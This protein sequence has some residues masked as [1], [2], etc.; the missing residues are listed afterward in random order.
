[1]Q[2]LGV[3]PEMEAFEMGHLWF[4]NQL[5]KEG[6]IDGPPVYQICLGIPWGSPATTTAMKAMADMVPK[7]GF[8]AGFGIGRTQM[9]MAAQ[10]VILGGNVRVGLED[11]LY[12]KKGV[13]ASNAQLVEKARCI[14]EDLGSSILNPEQV[15]EKLKL[16]KHF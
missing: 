13:F 6:L 4:A 1:M 16:K 5:Y 9:P 11:N 12:L 3:K 7:E 8:W 10:A 2:E 15:R 14:V